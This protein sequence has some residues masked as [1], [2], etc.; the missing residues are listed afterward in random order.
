[1]ACMGIV[2]VGTPS[3]QTVDYAFATA[4]EIQ[5]LMDLGADMNERGDNG[6]TSLMLAAATDAGADAARVLIRA[7]VRR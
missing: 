4:D 3:I 5:A 7:G 6:W 1:M 2:T